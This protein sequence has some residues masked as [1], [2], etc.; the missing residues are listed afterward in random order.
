MRGL[1][2]MRCAADANQVRC[3]LLCLP[4]SYGGAHTE[5]Q[6]V[7]LPVFGLCR[8]CASATCS[9]QGGRARK[10]CGASM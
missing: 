6:H 5:V 2:C 4:Y 8:I 10:A 7:S 1:L 9:R 3:L